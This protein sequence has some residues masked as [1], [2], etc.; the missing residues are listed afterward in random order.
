MGSF[1]SYRCSDYFLQRFQAKKS[2]PSFCCLAS[3]PRCVF[4]NNIRDF[5]VIQLF[6]AEV[7][8]RPEAYYPVFPGKAVWGQIP[9]FVIFWKVNFLGKWSCCDI[10]LLHVFLSFSKLWVSSEA[11][12]EFFFVLL[13]WNILYWFLFLPL[14]L[15]IS[16]SFPFYLIPFFSVHLNLLFSACFVFTNLFLLELLNI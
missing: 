5:A 10:C 2:R 11:S 12:R 4:Q 6:S 15:P 9:I 3:S 1:F 16:L 8:T 14:P 13:T 7:C